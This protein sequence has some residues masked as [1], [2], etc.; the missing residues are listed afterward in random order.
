MHIFYTCEYTLIKIAISKEYNVFKKVAITNVV[1]E[2]MRT[3]TRYK[4]KHFES[5]KSILIEH[6]NSNLKDYLML[7]I[8]F[9][10]GVMIG[11][12]LINNSS[13]ESKRELS[14]YINSFISTVKSDQYTVDKLKL[15]QISIV[16]N[17]KI[18]VIIWLAGSTIIGIPLIYVIT[19][20]KGFC[21][22]YTISAIIISLGAG[23]RYFIFTCCVI[24]TKYTYY[25]YNINA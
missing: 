14:G 8:I 17:L 5:V 24:S 15:T 13:E 12:I 2:L 22:G 4:S 1:E 9:I 23:K 18:I 10:I 20:Y 6:I 19:V 7:S 3:K 21:I 11:V 16:E 25:P